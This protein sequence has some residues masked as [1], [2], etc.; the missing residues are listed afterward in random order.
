MQ[1]KKEIKGEAEGKM[2]KEIRS[3]GEKTGKT[4]KA[5]NASPASDSSRK[6]LNITGL[7]EVGQSE[8]FGSIQSEQG[9]AEIAMHLQN[10]YG[11]AYVQRLVNS[12]TIQAKLEVTQPDD[13]YE[14]EADRVADSITKSSATNVQRQAEEEE[15]P[16]QMQEDEEELLQGKADPNIQLKADNDIESQIAGARSSGASL[17]E[18]ELSTLEPK[19]GHDF[20]NVK[21]HTDTQ[22]NKL[23]R[24][25]GAQAFTTRSDIFFRDGDYQHDTEA[26]KKLLAHELTHVIQQQASPK[27]QRAITIEDLE[28]AESTSAPSQAEQQE[29]SPGPSGPAPEAVQQ[30]SSPGASGQ[31]P[32]AEQNVNTPGGTPQT[33]VNEPQVNQEGGANLPGSQGPAAEQNVTTQEATPQSPVNQQQVGPGGAASAPG[34]APAAEPRL[35]ALQS[36]WDSMVVGK[37]TGAYTSM[38]QD[39]PDARAALRQLNEAQQ[40]VS[41][42]QSSYESTPLARARISGLNQRL[43]ALCTALGSQVGLTHSPAEIADGLNPSG[44]MGTFMSFAREML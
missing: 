22:A 29:S 20:S 1:L 35:A 42:L 33:P 44:A 26:G 15:E 2:S 32:A 39:R 18:S 13:P 19:F 31:T 38:S 4:L 5:K 41:S 23:S 3:R 16:I 17:S 21:V 36:L 24:K 8:L 34:Q 30:E 12:K 25:L 37:V 27:I 6:I 10:T 7:H 43:I 40:F 14:V 28:L 11:N 9:R